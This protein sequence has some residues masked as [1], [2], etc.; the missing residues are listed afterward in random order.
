MRY[1]DVIWHGGK[2][3]LAICFVTIW[4]LE[5]RQVPSGRE[6]VSTAAYASFEPV[7]RSSSF[8]LAVVLK[9]RPGF[10]VNAREKSADYLIATDLHAAE[11]PAGFRAGEV[12]YPKGELHNFTFSKI[13]LNIYQDK[14][15]LRM[16]V[17]VLSNVAL[18]AQSIPLKLRYQAC[19]NEI[20]L[21]PVTV[22]V[23]APISIAASRLEGSSSATSSK[24]G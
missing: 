18:G 23:Y 13:P 15:I 9:I 4:P 6:V 3:L 19:S 11:L 1:L 22:D 2:I 21:P 12:S 7:A 16:P 14:A 17:T 8:Q 5:P 20:C 24:S 10:H